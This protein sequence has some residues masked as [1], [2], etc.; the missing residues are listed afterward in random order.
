MSIR[1]PGRPGRRRASRTRFLASAV[2]A[3]AAGCAALCAGFPAVADADIEAGRAE[4][5]YWAGCPG[6]DGN[7]VTTDYPILAGQTARYVY[8]Q[9]KDY[10]AGRRSHDM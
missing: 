4:A 10:K 9:L 3:F 6:G 7:W 8:I 1:D 2:A 5:V